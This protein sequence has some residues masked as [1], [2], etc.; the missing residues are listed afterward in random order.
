MPACGSCQGNTKES[1]FDA[2]CSFSPWRI[3]YHRTL[4]I[5]TSYLGVERPEGLLL[6]VGLVLIKLQ[7]FSKH[8][9]PFH[10]LCVRTAVSATSP[11]ITAPRRP[12]G[13]GPLQWAP[14]F[15]ALYLGEHS[16]RV[17]HHL[18]WNLEVK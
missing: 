6:R 15:P 7:A 2:R 10:N 3:R 1:N 11:I 14:R 16:L 9:G 4:L 12:G 18:H 13:A 17:R 8:S 5:Q